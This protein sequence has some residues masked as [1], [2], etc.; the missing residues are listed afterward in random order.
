MSQ[1]ASIIKAAVDNSFLDG[2]DFYALDELVRDIAD[3]CEGKRN[4]NRQEFI[5]ACGLED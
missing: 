4:F 3:A 2:P 1:L 5:R